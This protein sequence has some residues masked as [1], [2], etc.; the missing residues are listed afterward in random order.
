M[1]IDIHSHFPW[2][3]EYS[4]PQDVDVFV[5]RAERFG[6]DRLCSSGNVVLHGP[7]PTARQVRDINRWTA[8]AMARH[9]ERIVGLCF[10]NPL[11]GAD[12]VRREID[13]AI[14]HNGFR[15]IKLLIAVNCRSR[16]LDP[17]MTAAGEL[18]VPVLH[19]SAYNTLGIPPTASNPA[20][21]ADLAGRFPGVSIIMAHLGH[22]RV[23]GLT[24]IAPH[25]NLSVDVSGSQPTRGLLEE[26][27]AR[28]GAERIVF[29]TDLPIRDYANMLGKMYEAPLTDRQRRMILGQNAARLL[30][31]DLP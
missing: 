13:W 11:A 3:P 18:G 7:N 1:I 28:L 31:L 8:Q 15:G 23:Q 6:V 9:P 25:R 27:V 4:R 12:A 22:T 2:A 24:E 26:A 17:I 10:L 16:K 14:G 21:M 5:R 20:D 29:G 30:R 19:H